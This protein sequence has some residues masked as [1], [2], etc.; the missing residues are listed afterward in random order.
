MSPG[1]KA[2]GRVPRGEDRPR[3]AG[4][5]GCLGLG[6]AS[7]GLSAG[8]RGARPPAWH[9]LS[10]VGIVA[11]GGHGERLGA[12]RPKALVVCAGKPLLDW[13]L[14][15]LEA[16]CDRVVVALPEGHEGEGPDRVPCGESR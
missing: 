9:R 4:R 8:G 13:S 14:D 1:L 5:A 6:G 16:T 3:A 7:P 10:V 12:D 2:A 15:V 11:A